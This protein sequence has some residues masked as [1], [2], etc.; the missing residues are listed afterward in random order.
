MVIASPLTRTLETASG[1]FGG[2]DLNED[3]PSPGST[4]MGP[5]AAAKNEVS[6]HRGIALP[7]VPFVASELC[8]ER[9]C[10]TLLLPTNAPI[11]AYCYVSGVLHP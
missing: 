8:R 1:I 6:P 2:E 11:F 10:M 9:I 5:T 3:E 4:L 7:Q